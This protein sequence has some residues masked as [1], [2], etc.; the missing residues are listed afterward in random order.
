MGQ[1]LTMSRLRAENPAE[2]DGVTDNTHQFLDDDSRLGDLMRGE[3]ATLGKSL[4][5][6]QR[7]LRIRASYVAAIENCDV[8]AFEA[9]SFIAGYVRSYARYLGMDPD[10][11][12]S[13][14]CRESG[15]TP[16][17][18]ITTTVVAPKPGRSSDPAE[19]LANHRALFI[20]PE[21]SFWSSVEPRAIGS[22]AVL[23][24]VV[25]GLGYGAWSVL[26]EVQRVTLTPGEEAPGVVVAL[27]PVQGADLSAP[28]LDTADTANV[29]RNLPQPEA[30][31]RLYRPQTLEPP[32]LAARDGPIA[33]IDPGIAL[34]ESPV[35]PPSEVTVSTEFGP[36]MPADQPEVA[37]VDMN[38]P[39]LE[40]LAARPAWV[41]VTLADGSVLLEKIMD[42]GERFTLPELDKPPLLRT[43]NSGAVYFALN[44][45]T[46]GPAAP[47]PQVVRN[48]E[49]SSDHLRAAYSVADLDADPELAQMI[50]VAQADTGMISSEQ[51]STE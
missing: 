30:L 47:G 3:R 10:W 17:Q 21:E 32:V 20:P 43:G 34:P 18:G 45:Q 16:V 2:E 23:L 24:L 14:F 48:I 27:D 35:A 28:P 37:V 5:D 33:A 39:A 29:V 38:A 7:E 6:V 41:R 44:G 31:D 25:G 42:S 12:F 4:L 15:L 26:Q 40:L 50:S 8:G 1:G 11:A 46:Y 13:K 19:V 36:E 9:P 51:T 22:L 49:L